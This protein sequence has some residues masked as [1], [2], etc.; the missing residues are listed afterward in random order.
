MINVKDISFAYGDKKVLENFSLCINQ[1][2]RICLF[3]ESGCGKTTLLRLIAGLEKEISGEIKR[4]K[5]LKISFVFQENLLLPFKT[6]LEN[7]TLVGVSKQVATENLAALGVQ[8]AANMLPS[9]LS[10]GM[11]R[12]VAI[13]RALSADFDL[14]ILDEPFTGLDEENI[15]ITAKRILDVAKD[16]SIILVTHSK[17]E[18]ELFGAKIINM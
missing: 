4:E 9:S 13:A 8:D 16:R 15:N 2:D 17:N 6:A 5:E 18:A 11:E 3:G 14:L 7:I 10:G 12:R 1:G